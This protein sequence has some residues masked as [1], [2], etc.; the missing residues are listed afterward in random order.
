M[1]DRDVAITNELIAAALALLRCQT[2]AL[3]SL[4]CTTGLAAARPPL[5]PRPAARLTGGPAAARPSTRALVLAAAVE[6]GP[7]K[8][9]A[10]LSGYTEATADILG[11]PGRLPKPHDTWVYQGERVRGSCQWRHPWVRRWAAQQRAATLPA[12]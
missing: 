3:R 10:S 5:R 9:C 2:A 11:P 1:C 4:C 7:H 12:C 6:L 8:M